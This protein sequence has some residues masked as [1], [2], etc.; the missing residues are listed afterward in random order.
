MERIRI[1]IG[2]LRQLLFS[3]TQKTRH[4]QRPVAQEGD[5]WA[6]LFK[7]F[8]LDGQNWIQLNMLK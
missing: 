6:I 2:L 1:I 7:D 8:K 5:F 3:V 4:V